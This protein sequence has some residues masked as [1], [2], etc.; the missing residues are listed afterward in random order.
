MHDVEFMAICL[1]TC[2]IS[3]TTQILMEHSI[4]ILHRMLPG[5][6]NCGLHQL[7]II[8][9]LHEAQ[10]K[11]Y[12]FSQKMACCTKIGIQHKLLISLICTTSKIFH[13]GIRKFI[14][15]YAVFGVVG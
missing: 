4:G 12:N 5:K 1:A 2:F 14:Y 6:F 15:D 8:P 7:Y 13:Y 11:L 10:I 9:I 3:E